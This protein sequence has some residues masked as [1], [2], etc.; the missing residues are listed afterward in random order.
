MISFQNIGKGKTSAM[1]ITGLT[2]DKNLRRL[3]MPM[4]GMTWAR[5][6]LW[7]KVRSCWWLWGLT[8]IDDSVW[9]PQ[10]SV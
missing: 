7:S 1:A 9:A 3:D 4:Q 2:S 8:V 10:N 6:R 5:E